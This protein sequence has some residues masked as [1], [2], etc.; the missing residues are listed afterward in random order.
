MG[1]CVDGM[2]N[3]GIKTIICAKLPANYFLRCDNSFSWSQALQLPLLDLCKKT[4]ELEL[5]KMSKLYVEELAIASAAAKGE[6]EWSNGEGCHKGKLLK[7]FA[8]F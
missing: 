3:I 4:G 1:R 7:K 8:V 2:E 6:Y 5:D